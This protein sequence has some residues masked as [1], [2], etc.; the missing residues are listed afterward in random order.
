MLL[1]SATAYLLAVSA[2]VAMISTTEMNVEALISMVIFM[3][4]TP[5]RGRRPRGSTSKIHQP[6]RFFCRRE[7]AWLVFFARPLDKILLTGRQVV[8]RVGLG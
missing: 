7:S 2:R 8:G 1:W 5:F 6:N 4:R 3:T